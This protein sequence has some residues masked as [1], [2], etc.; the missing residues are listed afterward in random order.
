MKPLF[1]DRTVK[2]LRNVQIRGWLNTAVGGDTWTVT[3]WTGDGVSTPKEQTAAGT[4]TGYIYEEKV[5]QLTGSAAGTQIGQAQWR[6]A[7]LSGDVQVEDVLTS[8]ADGRKF[9][10]RA[11]DEDFLFK[12]ADVER[13][14]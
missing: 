5:V 12:K 7:L 2:S 9:T 6:L 3:R 1:S 8:I 13:V 4:I 14:V 10:V 11:L